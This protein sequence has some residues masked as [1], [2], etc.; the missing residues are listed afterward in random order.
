MSIVTA[1]RVDQVAAA[2]A[3]LQLRFDQLLSNVERQTYTSYKSAEIDNTD[4]TTFRITPLEHGRLPLGAPSIQI[5]TSERPFAE[6]RL[7][8]RVL[9][10]DGSLFMKTTTPSGVAGAASGVN[11]VG[12]GHRGMNAVDRQ[13]VLDVVKSLTVSINQRNELM[14]H[15][16]FQFLSQASSSEVFLNLTKLLSSVVVFAQSLDDRL[17]Q[18][19]V[20]AT[21][22]ETAA[23]EADPSLHLGD[24]L[25]ALKVRLDGYQRIMEVN[26]GDL[27]QLSQSNTRKVDELWSS[28]LTTVGDST[29]RLELECARVD[30][31]LEK[32]ECGLQEATAFHA[33]ARSALADHRRRLGIIETSAHSTYDLCCAND[34]TLLDQ[35]GA[36]GELREKVASLEN[37]V[38][39]HSKRAA[40]MDNV[41][42]Q[43]SGTMSA[44]AQRFDEKHAELR[45][46]L[47]A[48]YELHQQGIEGVQGDIGELGARVEHLTEAQGVHFKEYEGKLGS[49]E[50]NASAFEEFVREGV[51]N[52]HNQVEEGRRVVQ[53]QIRN[54][55]TEI[56][57]T[58]RLALE[59]RAELRS[60]VAAI[61]EKDTRVR[62]LEEA[63]AYL[64][65]ELND[66]KRA[67]TGVQEAATGA[68]LTP[69]LLAEK[70]EAALQQ[71]V[72]TTPRST[73]KLT[74]A[75]KAATPTTSK[76]L[77]V[78]SHKAGAAKTPATVPAGAPE[79]SMQT[80]ELFKG[81][82]PPTDTGGK[83]SS[84]GAAPGDDGAPSKTRRS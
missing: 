45:A 84:T 48:L 32:S 47:R 46:E 5:G 35:R 83:G 60:E 67:G 63:V 43:I 65:Q 42:L 8:D 17:L 55:S 44:L 81:S 82:L 61:D 21:A 30:A 50:D 28:V 11:V 31:D 20:A 66:I 70:V 37:T 24:E 12:D 22:T 15:D 23:P 57:Q 78:T 74:Q 59:V 79:G 69:P 13:R 41:D 76:P 29:K 18:R 64:K 71:P 9:V 10:K 51:R 27:K 33:D 39:D 49:V 72:A 80:T 68:F 7:N 38:V 36:L 56:S 16:D 3:Q 62:Q 6:V 26:L 53:K 77:R 34:R 75:N 52:M 2:N 14:L 1:D 58:S 40:Q 19:E 73:T 54:A 4:L 25:A